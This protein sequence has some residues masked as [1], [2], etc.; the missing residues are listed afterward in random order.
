M[1]PQGSTRAFPPHHPLIPVDYQFTG[2]PVMIGGTM[3]RSAG[4][5]C[6]RPRVFGLSVPIARG[7]AGHLQL[8]AHWHGEGYAGDFRQARRSADVIVTFVRRSPAHH[9]VCAYSTCHGAGR[10]RSRNNS[11]NKLEYQA[12]P[13]DAH[14]HARLRSRVRRRMVCRRFLTR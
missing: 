2:Q 9:G 8:R 4:H 14:A 13:H 11:R 7:C 1:R 12:R 5:C 10:A 6:A 3:A